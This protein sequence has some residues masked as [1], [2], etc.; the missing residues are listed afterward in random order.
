MRW[1]LALIY[2]A[3]VFLMLNASFKPDERVLP[4][5]FTVSDTFTLDN[6]R[7]VF[8][9]VNFGRFFL[10]SVLISSAI[11]LLGLLVNSLAGYALARLQWPGRT[12]S[13]ALTLALLVLPF[14]TLAIP[15]YYLATL[16]GARDTYTAQIV[17]FIANAFSIYLFYSFFSTLPAELEAAARVDGATDAQIFRHVVIP[18]ARPVVATVALLTFLNSWAQYLW[19]ML[20][21]SGEQVRP[22]PLAMAT[23]YGLPPL[24]WG[25]LCAFGVM[26]GLPV[27]LL[28]A[29]LQRWIGEAL[30]WGGNKG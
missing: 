27:L 16:S 13:L 29:W 15:L 26:T 18:N 24:Q 19:P 23:F 11:T 21:T 10:N 22:L 25:D 14:E 12:L 30:S 8:R 5:F 4:E 9:R 28:F 20:I 3:P 2:L 1:L 6:Y 7:D 17:P